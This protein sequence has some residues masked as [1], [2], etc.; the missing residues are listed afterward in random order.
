MKVEPD[1][2]GD[3][4]LHMRVRNLDFKKAREAN[5]AYRKRVDNTLNDQQKKDWKGK[6][7]DTAFGDTGLGFS[8][9]TVI[10]VSSFGSSDSDESSGD[11]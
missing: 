3:G 8:T 2:S 6:G 1:E 9:G 11:R 7:Y 5:D 4:R 10:S